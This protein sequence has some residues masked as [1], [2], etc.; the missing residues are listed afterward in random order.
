MNKHTKANIVNRLKE[1]NK[2][3]YHYYRCREQGYSIEEAL[4]LA[5]EKNSRYIEVEIDG[6]VYPLKEAMRVV[7][8]EVDYTTV[9]RRMQNGM[10]GYEAITRPSL[11]K[12]K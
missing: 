6:I 12:Y 3:E 1:A 10:S 4:E 11:K 2:S 8:C 7:N 9:L 5:K